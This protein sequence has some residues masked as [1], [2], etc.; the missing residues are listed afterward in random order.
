MGHLEEIR[1]KGTRAYAVA[2][3]DQGVL[4]DRSTSESQFS[5]GWIPWGAR[6]CPA[7]SS[8]SSSHQR[9]LIG[10][11]ERFEKHQF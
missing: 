9:G 2:N 6:E 1:E 8:S 10:G 4:P 5:E 3:G 7:S 11:G